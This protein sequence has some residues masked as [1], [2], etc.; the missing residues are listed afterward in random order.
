MGNGCLVMGHDHVGHGR[1]TAG[2][3]AFV[4]EMDDYVDPVIAHIE[5]VQNWNNCGG[6][7]LP[8]FL[9]GHS[10]GGLISLHTL[11]KKQS[12]FQVTY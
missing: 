3:R 8:V 5:A 7:Q 9:V 11:F 6:G 4:N 12:L 1:T 10:M 2:E